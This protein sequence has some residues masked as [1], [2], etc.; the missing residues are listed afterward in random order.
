MVWEERELTKG[1]NKNRQVTIRSS[2]TEYLTFVAATGE[3]ETS[4]EMYYE[5]ENIWL[6]QKMVAKPHGVS[7]SAISQHLKCLFDDSEPE[8][9]SVIK[10]YL[11]TA[12]DGEAYRANHYNLQA[13]ISVGFKVENERAVQLRKWAREIVRNH[14]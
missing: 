3:S 12:A 11:I 14:V 5:D 2:A 6:T 7:V 9:S 8:E 10:K 4:I 1:N 13:I